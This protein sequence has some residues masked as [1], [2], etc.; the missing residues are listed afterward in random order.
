MFDRF[1]ERARRVIFFA[2]SEASTLSTGWIETEHLLLGLIREDKVLQ[3]ALSI[4]A[5]YAIRKQIEGLPRPNPSIPT[6]VDLPLSRESQRVLSLGA[7]ESDK[8]H[9]KFIDTGHLVLGLLRIE[10]LATS[11]LQQKGIGYKGVRESIDVPIP[12]QPAS[13]MSFDP[14]TRPQLEG[15]EAAP[16]TLKP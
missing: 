12:D 3:D 15:I 4:D 16:S 2:R 10:C 1:T 7:E 6:S 14:V 8:L 11:L 13:V 5:M 9:H